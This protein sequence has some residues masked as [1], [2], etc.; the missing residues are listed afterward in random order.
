M[1]YAG[2]AGGAGGG[3][4]ERVRSTDKM[5]FTDFLRAGPP[6]VEEKNEEQRVQIAATARSLGCR[7]R[8]RSKR[9]NA[10]MGTLKREGEGE[11]GSDR[12]RQTESEEERERERE[13]CLGSLQGLL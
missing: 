4:G 7:A 13:L 10:L 6:T 2:G 12:E 8:D 9:S 3:G 11:T 5:S 1:F